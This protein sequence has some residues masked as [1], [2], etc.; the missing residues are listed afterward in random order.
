MGPP[1]SDIWHAMLDGAEQVL[2]DEGYAALTSRRVAE[3]IGVKQR[4]VYYYFATMDDLVV[5]TFKRLAVRE[6]ER[7]TK[8]LSSKRPLHEIWDVFI[9]TADTR[10][11]TEFSALAN[12]NEPL[13][14][15]VKDYIKKSRK[16][17][18][19]AL[20]DAADRKGADDTIPPAAVIVFATAAALLLHRENE[21]GIR[22]GHAE[23]LAI[24]KNYIA[25]HKGG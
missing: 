19:A 9:H 14:K 7:L 6:L 13:R 25:S 12:H 4:L 10:L 3:H 23:T 1:G 21:L 15:E 18:I 24:I 8:A 17:Q 5:E 20:S 11:V 2:R 22:T 16:L